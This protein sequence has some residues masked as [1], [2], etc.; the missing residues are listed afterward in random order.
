VVS[1]LRTAV[2]I[3]VLWSVG[4]ERFMLSNLERQ[5]L[6]DVAL[7]A[8]EFGLA[9]RREMPVAETDFPAALQAERASF[10]TLRNE[11]ELLGCIGTLRAHRPLVCDVAHNAYHAAFSDPRFAPLSEQDL[12][13][14]DLHISLLSLLEP[15]QVRSEDD[16][17]AQLRI[18]IDGLLIE[19][20]EH[21]ATFLP[22]MWPRLG[23][24]RTFLRTLKEKAR[25]PSDY[26]SATLRASRYTAEEV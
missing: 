8:I 18:G 24:A 20:G 5:L 1:R 23:D 21:V 19:D 3:F 22:A 17:I 25:L 10:V 15:L 7:A 11:G 16:L 2:P 9:H 6:R 4:E 12:R 13:G 26:W 14:L